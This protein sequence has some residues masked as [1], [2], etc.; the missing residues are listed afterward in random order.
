M[1][2]NVDLFGWATGILNVAPEFIGIA[3]ALAVI[4]AV[5]VFIYFRVRDMRLYKFK[6]TIYAERNNNLYETTDR[7]AFMERKGMRY[8]KMKKTKKE[9]T[10]CPIADGISNQNHIFLYQK[11]ADT[12]I[13]LIARVSNN[14]L[15]FEPVP[16]DIKYG[17]V[18]E[19]NRIEKLLRKD[20]KLKEYF[21]LI[22]IV[23][24]FLFGVLIFYFMTE[25][26]SPG[27]MQG[28]ADVQLQI[29]QTLERIVDKMPR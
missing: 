7:G 22:A 14:I 11:D 16:T 12:Y 2:D 15:T 17:A 13:Q 25:K 23:L 6:V 9:L 19:I 20:S 3:V 1:A 29:A 4:L 24:V 5:G 18:L 10:T 8:F 27:A 21:P 28:I 26:F